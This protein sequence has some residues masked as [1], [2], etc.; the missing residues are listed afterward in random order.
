MKLLDRRDMGI[1]YAIKKTVDGNIH[2]SIVNFMC[3]YSNSLPEVYTPS[4]VLHLV[5]HAFAA[6]METYEHPS[7]LIT[8]YFRW[9]DGPWHYTDFEAMC[10]VLGSEVAVKRLNYETKE[11]EYING[12]GPMEDFFNDNN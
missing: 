7:H 4:V 8:E 6:L 1:I 2:K 10:A 5:E 3:H 9:K 12:F 11:Y